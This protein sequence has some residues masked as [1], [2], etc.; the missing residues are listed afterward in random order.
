[1]ATL[2]NTTIE[3]STGQL[4]QNILGQ[5][6][7]LSEDAKVS[8]ISAY[9]NSNNSA[10]VAKFALYSATSGSLLAQTQAI[11]L[12]TGA[13]WHTANFAVPVVL[14]P[15]TYYILG[16]ADGS[17]AVTIAR[18]AATGAGRSRA[19]TYA[20]N[21]PDP[22]GTSTNNFRYSI[23]ATYEPMIVLGSDNFNR[24]DSSNIGANWT[25]TQGN[26]E[27]VSN[28]LRK[29]SDFGQFYVATWDPALG[30]SPSA[31]YDVEATV[32]VDN[33][34]FGQPAVVGRWQ[35]VGNF[36]GLEVN[37]FDNAVVL[38]KL[39]G[40]S[41]T[42]LDSFSVTINPNTS[43]TIRLSMVGSQLRGYLNDVER[44]SAVDTD[45]TA[46]GKPGV[47]SDLDGNLWH[48]N[49]VVYGISA[50]T[51][52]IKSVSGISLANIKAINGVAIA[53]VKSLAGVN[54]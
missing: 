40:G 34:D 29:V 38:Y 43:Y 3:A 45:H 50:S 11:S 6:S 21:F 54:N 44:V 16:W 23:Y 9:L 14:T 39:V 36:Y 10:R 49:F 17:S 31:D 27:I 35:S 47:L 42:L 28:T 37:L 8:S 20:A 19:L 33:D 46:T 22:H 5:V 48:D 7:V 41:F 12:P 52:N 4:S 26:W 1:M 32:G 51:S 30:A 13:Q 18:T 15:D 24:A 25:E 2:G 53:N